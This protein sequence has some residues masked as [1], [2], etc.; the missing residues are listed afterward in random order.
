[1]RNAQTIQF[2]V[3]TQILNVYLDKISLKTLMIMIK[4]HSSTKIS[5]DEMDKQQIAVTS[6]NNFKTRGKDEAIRM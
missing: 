3:K 1:M 5:L 6:M 2:L 4:F